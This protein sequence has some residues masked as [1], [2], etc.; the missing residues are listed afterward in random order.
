MK[1]LLLRYIS[2]IRRRF[3]GAETAKHRLLCTP[4]HYTPENLSMWLDTSNTDSWLCLRWLLT[5]STLAPQ[6][7]RGRDIYAH[8]TI[9]EYAPYQSER[10]PVFGRE[11]VAG[12]IEAAYQ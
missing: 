4:E 12:P 6:K 1:L 11:R 2:E 10:R 7:I 8:E 5:F 3:L 9:P